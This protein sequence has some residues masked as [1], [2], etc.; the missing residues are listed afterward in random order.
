M[1]ADSLALLLRHQ[2]LS[3]ATASPERTPLAETARDNLAMVSAYLTDGEKFLTEGDLV[4]ALAAFSYALGWLHYGTAIGLL[5][6][7]TDPVCP[8]GTSV[9]HFPKESF[10][11]LNEKALRYQRLLT[12]ARG[13]VQ[14][15]AEKGTIPY[16]T[17]A[18]VLLVAGVYA[19][20]GT[21]FIASED[22][23]S[24]LSCFSYGHGWL[25]AAVRSGVLSVQAHPELFTV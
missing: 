1:N 9:D 12:T 13:S 10:N 18:Q 20:R 5:V 3:A 21:S 24:A 14:Q 8:V 4:N 25:D 16:R 7:G 17:G 11:R 2:Y 22:L 6:S 19:T 23:E 15:S